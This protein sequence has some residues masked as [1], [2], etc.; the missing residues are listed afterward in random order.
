MIK[1]QSALTQSI[2][3]SKSFTCKELSLT[4]QIFSEKSLDSL[5][6][7][8]KNIDIEIA[9][10]IN[11]DLELYKTFKLLVSI[12]GIGKV[13]ATELIIYTDNFT[14]FENSKKLGSYCGVVPFERSSGIYKGKGRVS[15]KANKSLKTNLHMGA[16][17]IITTNSP[18]AEYYAR[19]ISEGIR[20]TSVLNAIRN[21]MLKA[22]FAIV[23]SG[24]PYQKDY[25]YKPA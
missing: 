14:K 21:K 19:R 16:V 25:V 23:K 5:A 11:N 2:N 9:K 15:K 8:I 12:P 1:N 4:L 18:F 20:P 6:L 7:D 22:A 17:A 13:T 24:I 3:E 10:T